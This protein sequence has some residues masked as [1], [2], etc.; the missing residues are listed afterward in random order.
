M[1]SWILT[2][3][4]AAPLAAQVGPPPRPMTAA[5]A[6]A[7]ATPKTAAPRITITRQTFKPLEDD[8]NLRLSTFNPAEP[9]YMLGLTR[10]VYLQGYGTVFSVELDL[11]QSPTVNPFHGAIGKQDVVSTHARK[12]KQL[13]LLQQAVR[14]QMIACAKGLDAMPPEQQL[15]M[16]VRLDYQPWEDTDKLPSQI[17]LSA[18]RKSAEAGNIQVDEQ[19]PQRAESQPAAAVKIQ[20]ER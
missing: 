11:I 19:F 8:F 6:P 20:A 10:G 14:N 12:L 18:D 5:P 17:V 16:V 2:A 15:V 7:A 3:A 1:K 13:P 9:V 4:L